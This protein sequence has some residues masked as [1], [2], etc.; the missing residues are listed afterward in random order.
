[1]NGPIRVPSRTE[2]TLMRVRTG[3]ATAGAGAGA[4]AAPA[5]AAAAGALALYR[6]AQISV[7]RTKQMKKK[8]HF[9]PHLLAPCAY[10]WPSSADAIAQSRTLVILRQLL[11]AI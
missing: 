11:E 10:W 4:A 6:Q 9:R 2:L 8:Q 5:M 3:A 7:G 1:M